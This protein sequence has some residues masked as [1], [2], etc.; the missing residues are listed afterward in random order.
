MESFD[1]VV[2]GAGTAGLTTAAGAA[3]LG[4]K[5]ALIEKDKLGGECLYTGCVP[6]KALIRSAKVHWLMEHGEPLGLRSAPQ[7][8]DFGRVME[9]MRQVI[10]RVGKHDD[11]AR[12]RR[13]GVDVIQ[14]TARLLGPDAVRVDGRELRARRIVIATGSRTAVPPIP[15]LKE[16]G[17]LTHVEAFALQRLPKS[18]LVLGGGP[19]GLELAQVFSRFRSDVTVVEMLDQLLPREDPEPA[20]MLEG[21]LRAEGIRIH[22]RTRAVRTAD[23]YYRERLFSERSRKIVR[24]LLKLLLR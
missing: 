13:M 24:F 18:V 21:L 22:L 5:V 23:F 2:I 19:I 6:S 10:A 7:E 16:A 3:S 17:F 4:A 8:V 14:G 15:G 12:F 9:R 11:P 20:R 1:L